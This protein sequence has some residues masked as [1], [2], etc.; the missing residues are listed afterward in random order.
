MD[1]INDIAHCKAGDL[2]CYSLDV[3]DTGFKTL[4]ALYIY[5]PIANNNNRFD[6][7]S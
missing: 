2:L 3:G 4:A 7:H 6:M 1:D 5:F